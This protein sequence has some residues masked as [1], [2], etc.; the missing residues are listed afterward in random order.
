MREG[1]AT[2]EV[3]PVSRSDDSTPDDFAQTLLLFDEVPGIDVVDGEFLPRPH[4]PIP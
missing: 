1:G 4:R 3:L 2:Q